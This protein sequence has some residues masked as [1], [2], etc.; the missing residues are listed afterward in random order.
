M[1]REEMIHALLTDEERETL[2]K[3]LTEVQTLRQAIGVLGS[4]LRRTKSGTKRHKEYWD[5]LTKLENAASAHAGKIRFF[6][7]TGVVT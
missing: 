5:S 6:L 1:T 4:R 3:A 7:L 2:Q